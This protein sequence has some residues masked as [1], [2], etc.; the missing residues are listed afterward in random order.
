MMPGRV[1]RRRRC[2]RDAQRAG[3]R[4][5]VLG[6]S[7][8]LAGCATFSEDGGFDPV[9]AEARS[10]LGHEARWLR[11]DDARAQARAQVAGLLAQELSADT[12]V[13]IAL[14]NNPRLQAEYANLGISE[15]DLVQAGRLPNP[16]FSFSKS[17]GGGERE[18]ERGVH[19]NV[20]AIL[21]MPLR[22]GVQTRRFEAARLQAAAATLATGF[23]AHAAWVAAVHARESAGY[24]AQVHAAAEASRELMSRMSRV[25]N[26][27]RLALARDQLFHAEASASLARATQREDAAREA[28]IRALGLWG[29]QLAFRL[30]ERLPDL[31]AA[32]RAIADVERAAIEQ[33]LDVRL[34]RREL[35]ALSANLDLTRST[36]FVNVF[37]AGVTQSRERGE[38]IQDGYELSLEIPIFDF[39]GA[40]VAKSQALAAQAADRL[41][42]IAIDARS[43]V[44]Q[45]YR[46][47]RGA[48]DIARH[49]RDEIVPLRKRISDEQLL[50]YNGMLIGVFELIADAREQVVS[51]SGYLDALRDFWR[52]DAALRAAMLA[53]AAPMAAMDSPSPPAGGGAAH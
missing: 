25:G 13:Q 44:R 8:L 12:A 39:G 6:A 36:R 49:Y 50:R 51:I 17:S 46:A 31:P 32:P 35:D 7:L 37:E 10:A 23:D 24:F 41:R 27:S 53:S 21:T 29:D 3:R 5:L 2:L 48:Y 15:S 43:E 11:D 33:R 34:A 22:V 47:Y 52:A 38:P 18:I 45:A 19:F 1:P 14:L 30:P 42:A 9:A 40:R 28:L 4:A 26:A 20:I 16:G